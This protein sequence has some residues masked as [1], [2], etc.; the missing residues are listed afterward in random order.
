MLECDS[1]AAKLVRAV[2]RQ[3][4]CWCPVS[5]LW[6]AQRWAEQRTLAQH[7][8]FAPC[9]CCL[10]QIAVAEIL[11][12][13]A[14]GLEYLHGLG[15]IHG[16]TAGPDCGHRA[17][18]TS[19]PSGSDCVPSHSVPADLTPGNV[20]LKMDATAPG[21]VL[22]KLAVSGVSCLGSHVQV[23]AVWRCVPA[24]SMPCL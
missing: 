4:K 8:A 17:A 24:R 16:G 18:R 20:L 12:Q 9:V 2:P 6:A 11:R 3:E 21:G 7:K 13:I 22:V 19:S 5:L 1:F 23:L 10:L 15:I 14:S